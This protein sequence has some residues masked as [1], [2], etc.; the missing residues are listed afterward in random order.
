MVPIFAVAWRP[1]LARQSWFV[2]QLP[3]ADDFTLLNRIGQHIESLL[4]VIFRQTLPTETVSMR[5]AWIAS[6]TLSALLFVPI[7]RAEPVLV[8][9]SDFGT[10][11]GAV[12]S[13]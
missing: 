2:H 7:G 10:L 13:M 5:L 4:S 12:A 8:L 3:I 6:L 11:D 9:Q 1:S